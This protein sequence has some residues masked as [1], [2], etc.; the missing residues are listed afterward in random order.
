MKLSVMIP[1]YNRPDSLQMCLN[2]LARQMRTADQIIVIIRPEDGASSGALSTW[3]RV[4][5]ITSVLVNTPGVVQALN[6]GLKHATGDIITITDDDSI[7]HP[8]W[9]ERIEQRFVDDPV[10]G[11]VGGRDVI[12]A[13]GK[14]IPASSRLVGHI[15][16]FGRVVG[17]HHIGLGSMRNVDVLKGVNMSWRTTAIAGKNFDDGLRGKGAQVFFE[18]GF[19]LE[20]KSRG[21]RLI[22]DPAIMVDHYPAPRFDNDQR[23]I[24]SLDAVEDASFN[25]YAVL[26]RNVRSSWRVRAAIAWALLV[27][28]KT[29][30][31]VI[32]GW[33][34]LLKKDRRG[35][36]L[37]RSAIR[38]WKAAKKERA[39]V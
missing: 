36:L 8:N 9:L 4:L 16:P 21:W 34:A 22:Y 6:E 10:I 15:L 23:G 5:P 38:A 33:A 31:G 19:S 27:G 25:F 12:Y 18:L 1:T 28:T 13:N 11:G 37:R 3:S 35:I 17:N 39:R 20:V 32:R 7:A 29:S 24:P 14:S 30:P 2:G 26:L